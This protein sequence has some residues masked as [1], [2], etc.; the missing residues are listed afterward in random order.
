MGYHPID[1]IGYQSTAFLFQWKHTQ[2][3][4]S[5]VLFL[6]HL[7]DDRFSMSY[8]CPHAWTWLVKL[9]IEK[10]IILFD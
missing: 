6:T 8:I 3:P 7:F 2:M 9:T 5:K 4:F 1:Y 10:L